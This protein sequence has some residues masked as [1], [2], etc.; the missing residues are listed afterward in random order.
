MGP[1][2]SYGYRTADMVKASMALHAELYPLRIQLLCL[3]ASILPMSVFVFVGTVAGTL[4]TPEI[5]PFLIFAGLV[6]GWLVARPLTARVNRWAAARIESAKAIEGEAVSFELGDDALRLTMP[7]SET[8][9]RWSGI[10]RV[11]EKD[12]AIYLVVGLSVVVISERA[13]ATPEDR[14]AAVDWILSHLSPEARARSRIA[15][16]SRSN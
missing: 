6:I 13:F 3:A 1:R 7:N 5:A 2:F 4:L 9:Q 15:S 16:A 12:G 11:F 10:H 8:V 14:P